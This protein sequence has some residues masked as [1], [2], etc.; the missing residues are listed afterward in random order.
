MTAR[1]DEK[2]GISI[3]L[4]DDERDYRMLVGKF[5]EDQGWKVVLAE[6]GQDGIEKLRSASFDIVISDIYM[7]VMD[8]LKFHKAVRAIPEFKRLPFLF[9]SA[10]D[11][12]FTLDAINDSRIEAFL[13][14]G[15]TMSE[16][17]EWVVYLTTPVERR[18][19]VPP[20]ERVSRRD[21]SIDR[22]RPASRNPKR[23]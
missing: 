14:K 23:R 17:K 1:D 3:L 21:P 2:P 18:P 7:P 20:G 15:R 11:D 6:H 19:S 4:V 13:R 9:V 22:A 8:G 10:Y 12:Q 5:L 16:L